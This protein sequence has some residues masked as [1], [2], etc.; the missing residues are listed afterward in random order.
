MGTSEAGTEGSKWFFGHGMKVIGVE[1]KSVKM[2][3]NPWH[4]HKFLVDSCK[5]LHGSSVSVG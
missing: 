1:G 5:M 4:M 3:Y 2:S